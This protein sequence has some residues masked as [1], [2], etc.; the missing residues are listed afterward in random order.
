MRACLLTQKA[1][2][3]RAYAGWTSIPRSGL[4][5]DEIAAAPSR[6]RTPQP[7]DRAFIS[8]AHPQ[9]RGT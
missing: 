9:R 6:A 1:M 2:V 8:G 5:S 7:H 4:S 3:L